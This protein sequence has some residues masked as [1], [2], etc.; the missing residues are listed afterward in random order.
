MPI[1]RVGLT[2]TSVGH[3]VITRCPAEK[4]KYPQ[5]GNSGR[6]IRGSGCSV[7][8]QIPRMYFQLPYLIAWLALAP[9]AW[10]TNQKVWVNSHVGGEPNSMQ[11]FFEITGIPT[12]RQL[13]GQSQ[14]PSQ[15][16]GKQE[17]WK[18]LPSFSLQTVTGST[19]NCSCQICT[20]KLGTLLNS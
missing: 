3:V 16:L 14:P 9:Y 8:Y 19:N 1:P 17:A 10:G 18:N 11:H 7:E 2:A 4:E 15:C 12:C 20:K 5:N 6:K 13:A